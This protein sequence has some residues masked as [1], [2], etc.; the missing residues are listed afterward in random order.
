[1]FDQAI[2]SKQAKGKKAEKN[3]LIL[4]VHGLDGDERTTWG[5]FIS[6]VNS[7]SSMKKLFD[8]RTF[9]YDANILRVPILKRSANLTDVALGLK[10]EI[11]M[12]YS[13]Y[14]QI[15]L[16]GHSMGGLICRQYL[17]NEYKNESKHKIAGLLLYAVPNSGSALATIGK[18][19]MPWNKQLWN[20][21]RF[22]N[23][24]TTLNH[25]WDV[26][27]IEG[28]IPT[29]YLWGSADNV[30]SL[31]SAK[32][33]A[34]D[35]S[36]HV[37]TNKNHRTVCKPEGHKDNSYLILS[38]FCL[39]IAKEG[40]ESVVE[41]NTLKPDVLFEFYSPD[42]E[43][44]HVKRIEDDQIEKCLNGRHLWVSGPSG[45]GKTVAIRRF[46]EIN[47]CRFKY[48]GLANC[49]N[50]SVH[51]VME[52]LCAEVESLTE[53][54]V[55]Y[56]NKSERDLIKILSNQII[57]LSNGSEFFLFIEEIPFAE[58]EQYQNFINNIH[59]LII[60]L[61]PNNAKH[62]IKLVLSSIKKADTKLGNAFK[63]V[64]EKM[65]FM[66]F[67]EWNNNDLRALLL[68]ISDEL[69]IPVSSDQIKLILD[70]CHGSPR[71]IKMLFYK[72]RNNLCPGRSLTELIAV[73]ETDFVS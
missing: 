62:S 72:Y 5:K 59:A 34:L 4:L 66:E 37:L 25:E 60:Y 15:F 38:G 8:I 24:L 71:F 45:V 18:F 3:K 19:A 67:A 21:S 12:Q 56:S 48:I 1:M 43:E 28:D 20:L 65:H 30:V 44:F 50:A 61:S 36:F 51:E 16:V 68:L 31:E 2:P 47:K 23:I 53:I 27:N 52:H 73:V 26:Y 17:V 9:G 69:E 33:H 64:R 49:L 58:D 35:T 39:G 55:D 22:S 13:N 54:E 11:N 10:T 29:R 70:N 32:A 63:K 6:L 40:K 41:A 46:L 14:E 57:H 42:V 7:D